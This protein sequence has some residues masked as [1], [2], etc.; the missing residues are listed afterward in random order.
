MNKQRL[1]LIDGNSFCYRAFYA[2]REL[3]NSRGFP[4]NAVYGFITMLKKLMEGEKPGLLAVTFDLKGPTF[5]HKRFEDYKIHRKPMPEALVAQIPV[6]KDIIRAYNIPIYE[7]QGFEADDI[8]GTI[9]ERAD[10]KGISTFIVTGDKDALQLVSKTTKVYSTHKE[11]IVYDRQKVRERFGTGPEHI[12]DIMA[13]MGDASDNI[14]GVPG[15]GEKTAIELISEFKDLDNLIKNIDSLKSQSKKNM[16]KQNID[17]AYLSRELATIDRAVDIDVDFK[18]MQ[19]K[20]PDTE[21]LLEIFKELEFRRLIDE[22]APKIA[23]TGSYK[24]VSTKEG[25]DALVRCLKSKRQW[26]FD[27][28]TTSTDPMYCDIVGVSFCWENNRAEYISF[29]GAAGV[30]SEKGYIL[31]NL[32]ILFEDPSIKK[33][34]QN[35]KYEKLLLRCLGI[36]LKGEYFDTMV[37]SYLLNPSKPN[38]NLSDIAMEHLG[39]AMT[40]ISELIGKGRSKITMAEVPLPDITEYCCQDSDIT[41]RLKDTLQKKLEDKA[42]DKL[43]E[44]IELP[45]IG[46]LSDMEFYGVKI[47]TGFLKDMSMVMQKRLDSLTQGIYE[48]AGCL[49]NIN[50]PKQLGGVLFDRLKLPVIKRTKTGVSTDVDVLKTLSVKYDLPKMILEYRELSKLISTY[51][52]SLPQLINKNT[53]KLHTSFNQ[54]VTATGRLSSSNPNLQNIPVK[55]DIGRRIRGAF[56]S[57]FKDGLILSVDYSQIELRILAHLSGDRALIDAFSRDMDIH[58]HTASLIFGCAEKDVDDAMRNQ[59]KTVNFGIIYGM[60]PYGLSKELGISPDTAKG[61][62]DAYLS[63]YPHVFEYMQRQIEFAREKGYILTMFNRRRYIPEIN[64]ANQNIRQFAERTAINTPIQGTAADVIK[65]AM[66]DI[67]RRLK[68][69]PHALVSPGRLKAKMILQVHD[70]LVFDL[71]KDELAK[72]SDLVRKSMEGVVRLKV[73]IKVNISSGKSWMEA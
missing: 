2:I 27:F 25:F 32:K 9:S 69:D 49:F 66:I 39:L 21:A 18:D 23:P 73:P 65:I 14:P 17:K 64:A 11:G 72:V 58:R 53:K 60:S 1:F 70:E 56:I 28:E 22:I 46:V 8:I 36:E 5:R 7:K 30:F 31:K 59:A 20:A 54:T 40:G 15:I 42:L 12:I 61:F 19:V 24:A 43:F 71:P 45:L 33:I 63:R 68:P 4:T 26:A 62:I 44:E 34:G 29:V 48:K 35:I 13:L 55:T 51:I 38:H 3:S 37:A 6:I 47:D 52:D 16:I 41:F 57:S 10:K 50:S 67:S